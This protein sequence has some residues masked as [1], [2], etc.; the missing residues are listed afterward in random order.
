MFV[1]VT[2]NNPVEC[3]IN[4][5][6]GNNTEYQIHGGTFWTTHG[7]VT[8]TVT[9]HVINPFSFLLQLAVRPVYTL[10]HSLDSFTCIFT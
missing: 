4:S 3:Y 6:A 10:Y 1:M 8:I 9:Q 5:V 2:W 7:T